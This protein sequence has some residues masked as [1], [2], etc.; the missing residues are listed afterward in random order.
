MVNLLAERAPPSVSMETLTTAVTLKTSPGVTESHKSLIKWQSA[1]L[2][3][4]PPL[5]LLP[6]SWGVIMW[7]LVLKALSNEIAPN[8]IIFFAREYF[9]PIFLKGSVVFW[10]RNYKQTLEQRFENENR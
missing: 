8:P 1:V 3:I 6:I 4:R 7:S 10:A 5:R 2:G 9:P